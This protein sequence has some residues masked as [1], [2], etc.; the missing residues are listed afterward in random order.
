MKA[1]KKE[2]TFLLGIAGKCGVEAYVHVPVKGKKDESPEPESVIKDGKG[3]RS[4]LCCK[5]LKE[6]TFF[7]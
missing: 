3:K 6:I 5:Y 2:T 4:C 1:G 7:V